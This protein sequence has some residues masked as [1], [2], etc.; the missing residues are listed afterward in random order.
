MAD[1]LSPPPTPDL[2][3]TAAAAEGL[4]R[5]LPGHAWQLAYT[6]GEQDPLSEEHALYMEA[7]QD[8]LTD[9]RQWLTHTSSAGGSPPPCLFPPRTDRAASASAATWRRV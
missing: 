2:G 5:R 7:R 4:Y 1:D 6:P 9:E 3:P 8:V